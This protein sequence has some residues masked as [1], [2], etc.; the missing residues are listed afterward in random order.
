M[1][2]DQKLS[3]KFLEASFQEDPRGILSVGVFYGQE[4]GVEGR[5]RW[6]R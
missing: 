4:T 1:R 6:E 5:D 3:S 2:G